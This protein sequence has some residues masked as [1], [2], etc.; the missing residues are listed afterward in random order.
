[1]GG[2]CKWPVYA[3]TGGSLRRPRGRKWVGLSAAMEALRIGRAKTKHP[4]SLRL[5]TTM[6]TPSYFDLDHG[7]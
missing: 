7:T 2:V 4:G 1:M 5:G 6:V 3:R